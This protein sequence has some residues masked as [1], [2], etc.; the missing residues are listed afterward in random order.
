VS[1]STETIDRGKR[2]AIYAREEVS[3]V[4]LLNPIAETMEIYRLE[5][6]RWLLLATSVGDATIRAEPFD[7]IE[8]DLF[9]LWGRDEP[10]A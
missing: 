7:A 6:G 1:P 2:L 4:W 3:H 10:R 9:R 8:L 5:G